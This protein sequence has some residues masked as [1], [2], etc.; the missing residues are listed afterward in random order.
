MKRS[1]QEGLLQVIKRSIKQ[2]PLIAI[3]GIFFYR[4][5]SGLRAYR[6]I[7]T[8]CPPE[9]GWRIWFMDYAGSGDTYL[10]CSYLKSKG[11]I[12]PRDAFAGSGSLTLKIAELFGF[13]R[14][15][16]IAPEA[17]LNVRRMER[18]CGK[19]FAL[20][21]L[22]YESDYLE[23]TGVLRR[24]EGHRGLDF[25][26]MLRVGLE[27]NCDI[28]YEERPW[29]QPEFPYDPAELNE[30]FCAHSL[31][32]GRTVLLAPYAGK[33]NMW[34]IP[35]E[36]YTK[37]AAR[38]QAAGY[39]VCTNSG[40]TK[41]EPPVPGTVPL[42][43]PHRLIRVFCE[44]AG[45]FVGLRSGLCDIVSAAE[46]CRKIVLYDPD[47][48]TGGVSAHYDF[49]SLRNM[50]LCEDVVELE[51]REKNQDAVLSCIMAHFIKGEEL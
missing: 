9:E 19:K 46:G 17:A 44:A 4:M 28:P 10:T 50:G 16:R 41:K 42:L 37:L 21:P 20:L 6:K 18:F 43:V 26:S 48:I 49:F 1:E 8:A 34:G 29:R 7:L 12:G 31:T 47:A 23:Y 30:I 38:L 51:I 11:L 35:M 22:L 33:Q 3:P 2:T 36:F 25:M 32:P 15:V 14:Y 45:G 5:L 40:D 24:T 13:A 27:A 39:T